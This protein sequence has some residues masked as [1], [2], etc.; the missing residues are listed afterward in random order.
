MDQ[1][2]IEGGV[3]LHGEVR[4]SGAKNAALPL[5]AAT[6]LADGPC[7]I[8]G[9]PDLVDIRT[10]LEILQGLGV[11]AERLADGTVETEVEDETRV[12]APYD[13]VKTMR[14]S[15]CVLGPLLG[16]RRRAE[17]SFPGGCVIG[18]RPVDL[19]LHGLACLGATVRVADGYIRA[20]GTGLA[21]AGKR[22][23]REIY[24]G[25][26]FGPTVTGTANVLSAAVLTAGTTVIQSAACEPEVADLARFLLAMGADIE[27]IGSPTLVVRGVERLHG[28]TYRVIADRIEAGTMLCAA[29]MTQAARSTLDGCRS[30]ATLTAPAGRPRPDGRCTVERHPEGVVLRV[31]PCD[32]TAD[33][34]R[35]RHPA[36]PGLPHGP[37]SPVHDPPDGGRGAI[38]S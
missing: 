12:R 28:T 20:D 11:R 5:L 34:R 22:G 27:G 13:L 4:V 35:H 16:R 17:V 36:V 1:F 30:R 31:L 37:A 15:V 18:P 10:M 6:I 2:E 3:P 23:G 29:A 32:P 8:E 21:S 14:A 24:L 25:G 7:R 9:I 33:A 26:P 19:H 38:R